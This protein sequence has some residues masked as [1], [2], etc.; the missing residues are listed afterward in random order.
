VP[1]VGV[2]DHDGA[3]GDGEILAFVQVHAVRRGDDAHR[4]LIG[5]H[6]LGEI[7]GADLAVAI[8]GV[9]GQ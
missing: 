2:E 9:G 4:R 1:D 6:R 8:V 7:P 5:G 3:G